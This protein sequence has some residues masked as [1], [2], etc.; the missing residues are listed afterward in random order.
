M[1][2]RDKYDLIAADFSEREYADP[3]HYNRRKAWIAVHKGTGEPLRPGDSL[4]DLG[5]G[6]GIVAEIFAREFGLHVTGVD[7]SAEMVRVAQ[8]RTTDLVPRPT[9]IHADL[10]ALGCLEL[11]LGKYTAAVMFRS[12]YYVKDWATF[13]DALH[14]HVE[15]KIVV[16]VAPRQGNVQAIRQALEHPGYF[17]CTATPAFF[18]PMTRRLPAWGYWLLEQ[19]EKLPGIRDL[20]LRV[21]FSRMLIFER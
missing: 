14:N 9:F 6:D 19:A 20:I 10:N 18:T 7:F 2:L 15:R 21:K 11:P 4:L 13:A 16:E 17:R 5:C 12:S 8:A 3:Y 1:D